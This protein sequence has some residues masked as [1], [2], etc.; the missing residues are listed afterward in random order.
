MQDAQEQIVLVATHAA[1][2]DLYI[3]L[4]VKERLQAC[5]LAFEQQH[6]RDFYHLELM[7]ESINKLKTYTNFFPKNRREE[8]KTTKA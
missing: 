2:N 4:I 1:A 5:V 7:M 3:D 6:Y 8:A